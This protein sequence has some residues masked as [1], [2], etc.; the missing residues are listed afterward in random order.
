[1][2]DERVVIF[3]PDAL[4]THA[5]PA[6][7]NGVPVLHIIAV[8]DDADAIRSAVPQAK[9]T[10]AGT[11]SPGITVS[12]VQSGKVIGAVITLDPQAIKD[13]LDRPVEKGKG[14]G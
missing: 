13:F 3:L 8:D 6:A 14:A 1:M 2:S 9:V 11:L 5:F 7:T 10:G 4:A 12:R